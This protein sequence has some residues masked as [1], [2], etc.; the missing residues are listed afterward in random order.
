MWNSS[1]YEDRIALQTEMLALKNPVTGAPAFSATQLNEFTKN[2]GINAIQFANLTERINDDAFASVTDLNNFLLENDTTIPLNGKQRQELFKLQQSASARQEKR[3]ENLILQISS[4]P[5]MSL[6]GIGGLNKNKQKEASRVLEN[7]LTTEQSVMGEK[8]N[9]LKSLQD[10]Y[11]SLYNI[12][13][14]LK[15]I[16]EVSSETVYVEKLYSAL[17]AMSLK[18]FG[19]AFNKD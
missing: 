14:T 19:A 3:L 13:G 2:L 8:F 16:E 17:K 18:D 11:K 9:R 12:N 1:D 7:I 15:P 5:I 4:D 10:I 6:T